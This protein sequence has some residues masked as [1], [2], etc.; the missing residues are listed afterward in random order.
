MKKE[1]RMNVSSMKDPVNSLPDIVH[2]WPFDQ[3]KK[4]TKNCLR[5]IFSLWAKYIETKKTS[6]S[7]DSYILI[8]NSWFFSREGLLILHH[9]AIFTTLTLSDH[10]ELKKKE[11]QGL[12]EDLG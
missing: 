11:Q 6:L 10:W 9:G 1:N 4:L 8:K 12:Y 2:I 7:S 3:I 5:E